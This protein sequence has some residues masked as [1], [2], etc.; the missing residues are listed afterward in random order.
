MSMAAPSRSFDNTVGSHIFSELFYEAM[1]K[2]RHS[3]FLLKNIV[4]SYIFR[5]YDLNLKNSV[6]I[7]PNQKKRLSDTVIIKKNILCR[8]SKFHFTDLEV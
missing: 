4:F 2:K 6:R 5:K 8:F 1:T 7:G 3:R